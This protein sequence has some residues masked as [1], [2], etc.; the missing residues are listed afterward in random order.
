MGSAGRGP[1]LRQRHRDTE[2]SCRGRR[3]PHRRVGRS[4]L[5]TLPSTC[6]PTNRPPLRNS[7]VWTQVGSQWRID[8]VPEGLL[9]SRAAVERSYR[10]F[11][12][13]FVAKPG[14]ILAPNPVLFA[15]SQ[16]M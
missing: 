10:E 14:G 13:Y 9:L 1:G 6:P 3:H 7:S 11:Q 5:R 2:Q 15:R 8:D 4:D 12:T 16:G